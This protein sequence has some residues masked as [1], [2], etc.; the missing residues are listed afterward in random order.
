MAFCGPARDT[1]LTN[2]QTEKLNFDTNYITKYNCAI[3][4]DAIGEVFVVKMYRLCK[5]V[6][7]CDV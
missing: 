4:C 6:S 1:I 7:Q 3:Q 2:L 5:M